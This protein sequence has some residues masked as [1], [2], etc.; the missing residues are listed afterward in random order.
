MPKQMSNK[1]PPWKKAL[2]KKMSS[3]K[4]PPEKI[5]W[6]KLR[7][8]RLGFWVYCQK[9]AYG[10]ILDFWIPIGDSSGLCIEVDGKCHRYRQASDKKRD[11]VLMSKGI[12]TF[13]IPAKLVFQSP[14]GVAALVKKVYYD[15]VG[16]EPK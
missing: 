1:M 15:I 10:Y 5:L 14:D 13:R 3:E 7:D 4:T 11:R 2:A 9:P 12:R 6:S 16:K 8:K